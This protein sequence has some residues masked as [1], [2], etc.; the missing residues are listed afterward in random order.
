MTWLLWACFSN[1][2]ATP[3]KAAKAY[4]KRAEDC[5]LL[6]SGERH[7]SCQE[8]STAAFGSLWSEEVCPEG[9]HRE[10]WKRCEAL[11][12]SWKC[13]DVSAGWTDIGETCAAR[14][15]CL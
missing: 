11:V 9:F 3:E 2:A 8:N 14:E 1:D 12:K 6:Q 7:G 5:G 15:I 13:D 4:C 10:G